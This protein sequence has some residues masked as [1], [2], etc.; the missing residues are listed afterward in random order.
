MRW[1]WK[2]SIASRWKR[3]ATDR[4]ST[5]TWPTTSKLT[6]TSKQDQRSQ[7][8]DEPLAKLVKL[9]SVRRPGP[10]CKRQQGQQ[11]QKPATSQL[12]ASEADPKNWIRVGD[13]TMLPPR[14]TYVATQQLGQVAAVRQP[15]PGGNE[16]WGRPGTGDL[17]AWTRGR[18]YS[19]PDTTSSRSS[20]KGLG[21][22]CRPPGGPRQRFGLGHPTEGSRTW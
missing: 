3:S 21:R 10:S 7:N 11:R 9:A 16:Q 6:I 12:T 8:K 4:T 1:S 2:K 13:F 19:T 5:K 17:P 20:E 15:T 14:R 18:G 22:G